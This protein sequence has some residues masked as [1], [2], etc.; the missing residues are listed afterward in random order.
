MLF[1][2]EEA[3][4]AEYLPEI[5]PHRET[6]IQELAK[7]IEVVSRG[8]KTDNI[9]IYGPPG[10]GKTACV[11]FVFKQFSE[12]SGVHTI[13]I[14]TWNYNTASALLTKIILSLNYPIPRRGLAKDEILEKLIE[15][16]S[17]L[18]K[19]MIVCLDE[20]DQLITKDQRAL[21]DLVRIEQYTQLPVCV[22]LIS[23]FR[24]ILAKVEPRIA[25]SLSLAEIEFKPYNL[26]EMK[27]ILNERCKLAF[28][29]PVEEGV[30]LLCANHAISRGG[31]VRVGLECLRKAS[32]I[33]EEQNSD[34]LKV[35]HVKMIL[36]D[37]K[38]LKMQIMRDNLDGVEKRIVEI[39]SDGKTYTSSELWEKYT[40]TFEQV[41][42]VAFSEHI[43]RL[44]EIG[45]L[46]TKE[47][48]RGSRGRK[49]YIRLLK[50]KK[51]K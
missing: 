14:N 7:I 27:D 30:V 50:R 24:N 21:Y 9:F 19:G 6:Q 3:L 20:V 13:Y 38:S 37:V 33:A 4:S 45:L 47:D 28:K 17:K 12:Y 40:N 41:S 49:V 31:D 34:K 1:K 22:I 46:A 43:K 32:R 26:M 35:E 16:L 36:K 18:K 10:I 29:E 23:N 2:N 25:S 44:R 42:R 11:K 15:I 39:L 48:R 51:F 8:K 5:L